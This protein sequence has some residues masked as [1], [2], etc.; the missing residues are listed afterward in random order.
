MSSESALLTVATF[1]PRC[2]DVGCAPC[3]A[4]KNRPPEGRRTPEDGRLLVSATLTRRTCDLTLDLPRGL[5]SDVIF[6]NS[7]P[8]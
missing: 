1:S 4:Q 2:D 3:R 5:R 7:S 8:A 6:A